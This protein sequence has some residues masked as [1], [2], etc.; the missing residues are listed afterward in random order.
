MSVI[1]HFEPY[2]TLP[3]QRDALARRLAPRSA[4]VSCDQLGRILT[5]F[6]DV[7]RS[8]DDAVLRATRAHD[9]VE[10]SSVRVDPREVAADVDALPGTLRSAIDT[11]LGNI[12]EVNARLVPAD[13]DA[14]VRPGTRVGERYRPLDS[15]A[16]YVPTRK[17]PL[18]STALML[19]GAARVAG[20]ARI[21][22][23]APPLASGRWE[24]QTFAAGLIA[25][26]SEFYV[27]N[28]VALIAALGRGTSSISRVDGIVGPGPAGIAAAMGIAACLGSR[29]V[30]GLGPT[31][32]AI[33]ADESANATNVALDL[34]AEAE[35][36][37]DSS[38]L[39]VTPSAALATRVRGELTRQ[40]ARVPAAR[41]EVVEH[42]FGAD[43][44]GALVVAPWDEAVALLDRYAPE[45]LMLAGPAAEAQAPRIRHAGELLLGASTPFAAANYAI[46]V[47]AVLPTNGFARSHSAVTARDFMRLSTTARLD[48]DA[49]ATLAPSIVA[50][51]TAEGLPCHAASIAERA[52][53]RPR[54]NT[55]GNHG[56]RLARRRRRQTATRSRRPAPRRRASGGRGCSRNGAASRCRSSPARAS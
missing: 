30:V 48:A 43:G 7:A 25:G 1:P 5:L 31:D 55:S 47:S 8:G 52:R 18:I 37:K 56:A 6:D 44:F 15:V 9:G 14:G 2:F 39:L 13:T 42:V 11:A 38:A 40:L 20:V 32:C 53:W 12:R 27:G 24:P 21:A 10:L 22:M 29:T 41:R 16:V 34:M 35:H 23:V 3:S 49:L 36:G 51:A 54:C 28:G 26:A 46:G 45:H 33:L 19:I 4:P 17:G 50:L